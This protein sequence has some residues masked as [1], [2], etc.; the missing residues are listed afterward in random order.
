MRL[1]TKLLDWLC[2]R[3]GVCIRFDGDLMAPDGSEA[4][5]INASDD[6]PG[7]GCGGVRR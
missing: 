6:G 1:L 3:L 5:W 2:E 4:W 7:D